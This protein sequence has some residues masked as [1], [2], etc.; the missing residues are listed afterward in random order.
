M[1][2]P[3][4][5]TPSFRLRSTYVRRVRVNLVAGLV[6]VA[7]T[8]PT[9]WAQAPVVTVTNCSGSAAVPNSLPAL[10]QVLSS[11]IVFA[12]S[13]PCS[14]ITLTSPIDLLQAGLHIHGPGAGALTIV[15][16]GTE[17]V[18]RNL[19]VPHEFQ[20]F[21][22]NSISGLTIRNG[23]GSS[24]GGIYNV[25]TLALD[26]V[27]VRSNSAYRGGGIYNA[28]GN[29][30]VTNSTVRDNIPTSDPGSAGGG[31]YS[32]STSTFCSDFFF[33]QNYDLCPG[34]LRIYNSTVGPN[35]G[36][37]VYVDGYPQHG[38]LTLMNSTVAGNTG[39]GVVAYRV[40]MRIHNSTLADNNGGGLWAISNEGT[41]ELGATLL[42]N[43]DAQG[44]NCIDSQFLA[45]GP[46]DGYN[47]S[48]DASC[49]FGAASPGSTSL[50]STFAGFS[51]AGL[52][53]NGGPTDTMA[54]LVN[55]SAAIGHVTDAS[56]CPAT[57]QRGT[58]RIAP[59]DTG[60]FDTDGGVD[61][62]TVPFLTKVDPVWGAGSG[63]TPMTI[64]GSGFTGA[65]AVHIGPASV[66]SFVVVD[67]ATI[68]TVTPAGNDAQAVTV[69]GSGGVVSPIT[70]ANRFVYFT[71]VD[72][73]THCTTPICV[74]TY[75]QVGYATV[76]V[77]GDWSTCPVCDPTWNVK[78][79]I[80]EPLPV[81]FK[82]NP[83]CPKG[84]EYDMD[85]V[86]INPTTTAGG[87][88]SFITVSMQ[89]VASDELVTQYVKRHHLCWGT[90]QP[91]P[92]SRQASATAL[93]THP[94]ALKKCAKN[95][96]KPPC[97]TS[98]VEG[99]DG[100]VTVTFVSPADQPF[101]FELGQPQPELK[102]L[103][104]E[105]G[106][107]GSELTLMGKNLDGASAVVIGGVEAPITLRKRSK[108][109]VT[110]PDG[111]KTGPVTLTGFFGSVVSA[112]EFT[113]Q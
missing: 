23:G 65:T 63:G 18:F 30:T 100:S 52:R 104:P 108:L 32:A 67:D 71:S 83:G 37:G 81:G 6:F 88:L 76:T 106:A 110:V 99:L 5:W 97:I 38:Y 39:I 102:K 28:G 19:A 75:P 1:T 90:D 96:P 3:T 8:A 27:V 77:S 15:G 44:V 2:Q 105:A 26:A 107:I 89:A 92:L 109:V 9:A 94:F 58:A 41:F 69:T 16:N 49:A 93:P 101:K 55:G 80:G 25:G 43:H 33:N 72:Q 51:P 74:E 70:P 53:N 62:G 103:K 22:G 42:A 79:T 57:D 14:T 98:T 7:L 82:K 68:T 36:D 13:P 64:F 95:N 112:T 17:P 29:L 113:V 21:T 40:A 34:A 87:S 73:T 59:C 20:P 12:L 91:A 78:E 61:I 48:D 31:I 66:A 54:L 10:V 86:R 84:L 11:E 35:G 60:A 47:I 4:T 46:D 111:A 56:K 24:G 50:N 85:L 45:L